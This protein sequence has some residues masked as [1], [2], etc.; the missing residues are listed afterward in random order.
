MLASIKM[1]HSKVNHLKTF[2]MFFVIEWQAVGNF[3]QNIFS[4]QAESKRDPA[5]RPVELLQ[6]PVLPTAAVQQTTKLSPYGILRTPTRHFFSD[7]LN[8]ALFGPTFD[9][10]SSPE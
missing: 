1:M 8:S 3:F 7:G 5:A 6:T 2:S 9:V 4:L 10:F